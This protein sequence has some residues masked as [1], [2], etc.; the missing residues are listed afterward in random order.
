[1]LQNLIAGPGPYY[2]L[3][4]AAPT[5]P[6]QALVSTGTGAAAWGDVAG[7]A[8]EWTYFPSVL[9]YSSAASSGPQVGAVGVFVNERVARILPDDALVARVLVTSTGFDVSGLAGGSDWLEWEI[10][11]GRAPFGGSSIAVAAVVEV[12]GA[13]QVAPALAIGGA[14]KLRVFLPAGADSVTVRGTVFDFISD[15]AP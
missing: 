11:G 8:F 12:D 7:E 2:Q 6:G 3:T 10:P 15:S 1:M 13:P 9:V 5:A 14:G 4:G